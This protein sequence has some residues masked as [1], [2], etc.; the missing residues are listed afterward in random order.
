[1]GENRKYIM[2]VFINFPSRYIF[3]ELELIR[4]RFVFD[5]EYEGYSQEGNFTRSG[6][7]IRLSSDQRKDFLHLLTLWE[8]K[9]FLEGSLDH[10]S[11]S[12]AATWSLDEYETIPESLRY[13][14]VLV[15]EYQDFSTLDLKLISQIPTDSNNGLFLTGDT[16]QK[17]YA[18]DFDLD[19]AGLSVGNGQ[20]VRRYINKNYRNSRE[21][22]ECGHLLLEKYCDEAT[23]RSEGI[24]ILKPEYALRGSARPFACKTNHTLLAAWQIAE[25]WIQAG[26]Q[27]FSICIATANT[28]VYS[29]LDIRNAAPE[30][31]ET[32]ILTG[33]YMLDTEKVI[34]SDIQNV[35]GFEFSLMIIIGLEEDTFPAKGFAKKEVWRDALRLYVAITRARDEVCIVYN[36]TPSEFLIAMQDALAEKTITFPEELLEV[37]NTNNDTLEAKEN[38]SI[39]EVHKETEIEDYIASTTYIESDPEPDAVLPDQSGDPSLDSKD[40]E[41]E[42][43][44]QRDSVSDVEEIEDL[45]DEEDTIPDENNEV[46]IVNPP[47]QHTERIQTLNG[48][49]IL[50]IRLPVTTAGL[51]EALGKKHTIV[52]QFFSEENLYYRP[53]E[54]VP[55]G[56]IKQLLWQYRCVPKFTRSA[57]VYIDP[58]ANTDNRPTAKINANLNVSFRGQKRARCVV[59]SCNNFAM[60]GDDYC[61]SCNI[62]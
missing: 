7:A 35:K 9:Q 18:K 24:K 22:L 8:K 49:T 15:D 21:I 13:R 28:E 61:Y 39:N 26:Y 37:W 32:S 50:P 57:E 19:E 31:R 2:G 43:T 5:G 14:C 30:K 62:E 44:D 59:D 45:I 55:D 53:N 6:R 51:A 3:E 46:E 10:M 25:E 20:R 42:T 11:L 34:I 33:D 54:S 52:S 4:S 38:D 40:N 1:M 17:I 47:I 36:E 56:W 23:A 29:I 16:G 58:I 60:D 27:P 48:I 12:Q 41:T